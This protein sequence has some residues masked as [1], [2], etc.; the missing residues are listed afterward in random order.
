MTKEEA[1]QMVDK[2]FG[3]IE[4]E[5]VTLSVTF[6]DGYVDFQVMERKEE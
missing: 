3:Q 5:K 4:W 1:R 2:L 6:G